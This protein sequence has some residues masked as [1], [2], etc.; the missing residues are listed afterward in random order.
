MTVAKIVDTTAAGDSFNAGY[1]CTVTG[2][3]RRRCGTGNR[4]RCDQIH[5]IRRHHSRS[6]DAQLDTI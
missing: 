3:S 2:G 6:R 5:S 1:L 4:L